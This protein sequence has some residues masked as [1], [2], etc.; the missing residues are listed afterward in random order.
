[1]N[2]YIFD[3][4]PKASALIKLEDAM[5]P[6]TNLGSDETKYPFQR[7]TVG[8]CFIESFEENKKAQESRLRKAVCVA[9]KKYKPSVFKVIGHKEHSMFEVVRIK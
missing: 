7:L 8:K 2:V 3:C 9:N 4:S 5:N 6:I 1:M